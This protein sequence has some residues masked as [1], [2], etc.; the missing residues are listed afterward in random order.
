MFGKITVQAVNPQRI[1]LMKAYLAAG[2]V[3][4]CGT[5]VTTLMTEN[6]F[7]LESGLAVRP[8]KG[9]QREGTGHAWVLTGYRTVDS[10][11]K[12]AYQGR[13]TAIN[14]WGTD[15]FQKSPFGPGTVSLPFGFVYSEGFEAYAIRLT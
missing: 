1:D 15:V 5:A 3:I 13:F 14:S 12:T 11:E 6:S 8:P 4:V 10:H 2:W 9:F 7:F